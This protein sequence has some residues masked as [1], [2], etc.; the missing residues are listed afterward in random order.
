MDQFR[1]GGTARY[2]AATSFKQINDVDITTH[3]SRLS[4]SIHRSAIIA[5][6]TCSPFK[7]KNTNCNAGEL[8]ARLKQPEANQKGTKNGNNTSLGPIVERPKVFRHSQSKP[9]DYF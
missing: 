1:E 9:L 2:R 3:R 8:D 7:L 5:S 4:T 6:A